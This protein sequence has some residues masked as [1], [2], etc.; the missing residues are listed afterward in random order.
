MPYRQ[1]GRFRSTTA[2][3]RP[4]LPGRTTYGGSRGRETAGGRT[5]ARRHGAADG[6]QHSP[7]RLPM[8][9][10]NRRPE[11]ARRLGEQG[12]EVA[13]SP[14]D[15]VR[16]TDVVITMVTDADAVLSIAADQGMLAAMAEGAIWAQMSTIGLSATEQIVRLV[17]QQRPD[18]VLLDAPVAGSR[19]PAEQGKLVILAP[20]RSRVI[21][22]ALQH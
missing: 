14:A 15:A 10:W 21:T 7:G 6:R 17:S 4:R 20:A 22:R 5:P 16:R 18:V 11:R 12:A 8:V 19:G 1:H 9:V 13:G 2:Q 3:R